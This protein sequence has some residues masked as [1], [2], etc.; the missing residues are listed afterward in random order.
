[1]FGLR[2]P[3]LLLI[4]AVVVVLFGASKLPQLGQGLGQGLRSLRK[5]LRES[6]ED[7]ERPAPPSPAGQP[8]ASPP[9]AAKS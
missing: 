2:L 4:L 9:P 1:M 6:Q 3:E 8:P 7:D 5:A